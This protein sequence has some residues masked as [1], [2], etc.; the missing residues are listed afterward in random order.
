MVL[1]P[2]Q[3]WS[4]SDGYASAAIEKHLTFQA[5]GTIDYIKKIESWV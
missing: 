1:E 5:E 4:Y 2:I 3:V